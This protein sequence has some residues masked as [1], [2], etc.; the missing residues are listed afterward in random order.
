MYSTLLSRPSG[1]IFRMDSL[2]PPMDEPFF[3]AKSV[4]GKIITVTRRQLLEEGWDL[5]A[6]YGN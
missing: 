5:L 2:I 4:S 6:T 1:H 3:R